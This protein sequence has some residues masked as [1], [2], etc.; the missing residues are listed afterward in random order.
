ME[1][2]FAVQIGRPARRTVF[3][4]APGHRQLPHGPP[5]IPAMH[6]FADY[7]KIF[8]PFGIGTESTLLEPKVAAP[9][10]CFIRIR[11][12]IGFGSRRQRALCI[13]LSA[14]ES[15]LERREKLPGVLPF[16]SRVIC[17]GRRAVSAIL[18]RSRAYPSANTHRPGTQIRLG[19]AGAPRSPRW[20]SKC[21]VAIASAPT[22]S[23]R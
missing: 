23:G 8:R 9:S 15:N 1:N 4:R 18:G 21:S 16:N 12:W 19:I 22:C 2:R 11:P 5:I 3:P 7:A 20:R 17:L 10:D 6:Q 14:T 13:H